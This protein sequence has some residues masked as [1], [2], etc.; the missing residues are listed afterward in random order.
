MVVGPMEGWEERLFGSNEKETALESQMLMSHRP[1]FRGAVKGW[2]RVVVVAKPIEE[3]EEK[4][5]E[6]LRRN[7]EMVVVVN[8]IKKWD[9]KLFPATVS[10]ESGPRWR[11]GNLERF[12]IGQPWVRRSKYN[13][14]RR[15]R[16]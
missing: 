7:V 15:R 14:R 8:P 3:W 11:K 6:S 13:K 16:G 10:E 12:E 5:E 9:E 2:Q 1:E 4:F